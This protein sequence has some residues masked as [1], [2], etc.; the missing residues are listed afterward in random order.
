M[1]N[2]KMSTFKR[3]KSELFQGG[4]KELQATIEEMRSIAITPVEREFD[5]RWATELKTRVV[6][7]KA[8]AFHWAVADMADSGGFTRMRVNGQHSSWA[9]ADLLRENALPDNLVIHLDTYSVSN[10]DGAVLLFR[11]F[12]ARKSARSKEDIS[13]A[14]QC[15]QPE[16]RTCNRNIL[17]T[18]VEGVIWYRREVQEKPV[19]SGDDIY[20]LFNEQRLHPF[21]VMLN[22]TLKSGKANELKRVPVIAAAYGTWLDDA[23]VSG[24]FWRLVALG[25]NRNVSDA[26]SDL[27]AELIRIRDEKEKCNARDLYAKCAK[28]WEA[29][30]DGARVSNFRVN[31]KKKGLPLL[32]DLAA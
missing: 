26:A 32:G 28:A 15:F 21:F 17:K 8:V 4:A 27:D 16:L 6:D 22:E 31:T 23:K 24:E 10:Q 20:W 9:L 2:C 25:S 29:H 5:L 3:V 19:A 7:G 14:Y 12:D 11:Q 1:E 18:A 13:G 30:G